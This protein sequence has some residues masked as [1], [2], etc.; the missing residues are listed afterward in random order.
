MIQAPTSRPTGTSTATDH[1]KNQPLSLRREGKE[2]IDRKRLVASLAA[3]RENT[4]KLRLLKG[5]IA[6]MK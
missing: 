1:P 3:W 4:S 6:L 2:L 5:L